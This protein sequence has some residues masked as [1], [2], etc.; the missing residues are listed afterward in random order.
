MARRRKKNGR[1]ARGTGRISRPRNGK[2]RR[3]PRRGGMGS[4]F[5]IKRRGTGALSSTA[6][7][8]SILPV[9]IGGGITLGTI[10]AIRKW[11]ISTDGDPT[12]IMVRKNASLVGIGAGAIA[13]I[14]LKFMA[15]DD[16]AAGALT[17][18]VLVGGGI[19]ALKYADS[20][21][22]APQTVMDGATDAGDPAA[23]VVGEKALP[24]SE[25]GSGFGAIVPEYGGTNGLGA[26]VMQPSA[27]GQRPGSI[28]S[29]GETVNLSGINT[30]VF[31]TP[32]F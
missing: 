18:A 31:G 17:S 15:N 16:A 14:A 7:Q 8:E 26:I 4:V 21:R 20:D 30:S 24:A 1:F 19:M 32:G 6:F 2:A 12:K 11:V 23:P 9:I 13:A 3:R 28:G 29:Y 27:G 10:F 25:G 22:S 5:A